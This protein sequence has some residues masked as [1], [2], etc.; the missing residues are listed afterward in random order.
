[1]MHRLLLSISKT[2]ES[3]SS[4]A[5]GAEN[6]EH[7]ALYLRGT[8]SGGV[9]S[10]RDRYL[11]FA[12]AVYSIGLIDSPSNIPT[13]MSKRKAPRVSNC[14]V[15]SLSNQTSK[16][17]FL[18]NVAIWALLLVHVDS[19]L[20]MGRSYFLKLFWIAYIGYSVRL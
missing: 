12:V 20:N 17:E 16:M 10:A 6:Q 3:A 8:Q 15:S 5:D 19:A 18:L 1:M 13:E 14:W 4:F 7:V 11:V 2:N 9:H